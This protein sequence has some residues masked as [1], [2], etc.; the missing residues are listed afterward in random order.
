LTGGSEVLVP[1]ADAHVRIDG[2]DIFRSTNELTDV[3]PGVTLSLQAEEPGTVLTLNVDRDASAALDAAKAFVDAYNAAVKFIKTQQTPAKA[4][5][6][7][8]GDSLLRTTRSAFSRGVVGLIVG[9]DGVT[10]TGSAA[11]FSIDKSGVL[12]LN[13]AKFQAAFSGDHEGLQSLFA[14]GTGS[15]D[16]NSALTGLLETNTG[17]LD[18]KS[19]GLDD[20]ILR[21]QDRIDRIE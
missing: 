8:Y 1:G 5:P 21:L 2:V 3:I 19:R 4:Q 17:T 14:D 16:L 20:Q 9:D 15:G 7:L 13:E 12:T 10:T 11:G 18:V 6:P